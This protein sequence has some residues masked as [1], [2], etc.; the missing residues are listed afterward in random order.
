MKYKRYGHNNNNA[1]S[2]VRGLDDYYSK[3]LEAY[4]DFGG[5]S[6]YFHQEAIRAQKN[7]FLGPRHIE[8][9]YATLA[10]WGMHR[11]GDPDETKAKLVSFEKFKSSILNSKEK[12]EELKNRR[13]EVVKASE[14]RQILIGLKPAYD[15][16]RV[17]ISDSTLVANAKTL[18]HILPDLIPPIDRQ[19]TVRFFARDASE[20]FTKSGS[21]FSPQVPAEREEQ[22]NMFVELSEKI[23]LLLSQCN[24]SFI[25]DGTYFNTSLPKI[26][27]NLI[28]SF[29]KS[30]NR[31]QPN[32]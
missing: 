22:F 25:V 10:S 7:D 29:V 6:V 24:R 14:Y 21:Y 12:Y 30:V 5:P 2:L 32:I 1:A 9:I 26:M 16:L 15:G 31:P 4:K 19:Y 23:K 27:D 3:S 28:M 8:M 11:M 20:F 13:I 17:S 18:A